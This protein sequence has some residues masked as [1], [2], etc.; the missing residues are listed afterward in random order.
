MLVRVPRGATIIWGGVD[1]EDFEFATVRMDRDRFV[2]VDF[3][4]PTITPS[5]T[6][7]VL[8]L[9]GD[10]FDTATFVFESY[11]SGAINPSDDSDFFG[12]SA[13]A[14]TTY[15][16]EVILDTHSD[17]ELILY[18]SRGN[19]LDDD[20][21]GGGDGGSL[22]EWTAP[23]TGDYYVEV[24]SF[25]RSLDAGSYT[26]YLEITSLPRTLS[27]YYVGPETS[28]AD[29]SSAEFRLDVQERDG[30]VTGFVEVSLPHIGDSDI[31]NGTFSGNVL[32]FDTAFSYIGDRYEC[33]YAAHRQPDQ[34]TLIGIYD[35][36]VV[37][38]TFNDTGTYTPQP[39]GKG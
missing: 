11:T 30:T 7:A 14:G 5:P 4:R 21:D 25:D 34:Q 29:G 12:F 20:D 18:D 8:D 31:L 10:T 2:T 15:T 17:T 19:L 23:I 39:Y 24:R 27:G 35:C 38:S 22:L 28:D 3:V 9:H 1:T 37:G 13:L 33:S 36:I 26:L 16:I 32:T 6:P